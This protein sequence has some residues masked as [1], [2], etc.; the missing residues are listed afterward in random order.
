MTDLFLTE[1]NDESLARGE[2]L[3]SEKHQAVR[4]KKRDEIWGAWEFGF[5][6]PSHSRKQLHS[7]Q[8]KW[9]TPHMRRVWNI[10]VY[11]HISISIYIEKLKRNEGKNCN[12]R[13]W[14]SSS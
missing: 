5:S 8:V 1:K 10:Y 4:E 6:K 11:I 3:E 13:R 7:D 12:E 9:H 2:S 14:E